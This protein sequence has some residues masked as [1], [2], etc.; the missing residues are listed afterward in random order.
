MGTLSARYRS[1]S[2]IRRGVFCRRCDRHAPE[3]CVIGTRLRAIVTKELWA[4]LRDP[5]TRIILIVPPIMQLM[6]FGLATTLEVKNIALGILN[7]DGGAWSQE[8]I[9]RVQ[10]SPN[11]TRVVSL[12]SEADARAAIDRQQVIAVLRF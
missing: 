6:I 2:R 7:R 9:E 4:I 10:G 1:S 8:I 11:V 5:R 12:G 3:D